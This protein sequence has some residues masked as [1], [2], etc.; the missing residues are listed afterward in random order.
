MSE[1]G[2]SGF[3]NPATNLRMPAAIPSSLMLGHAGIAQRSRRVRLHFAGFMNKTCCIVWEQWVLW[4][5]EGHEHAVVD[6]LCEVLVLLGWRARN[7][8]YWTRV[9]CRLALYYLCAISP[10]SGSML[11][12]IAV[13]SRFGELMWELCFRCDYS[14]SR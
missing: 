5:A 4:E 2:N 9:F 13:C 7:E 3:H 12:R 1:S 10:C 6:R 14:N 8:R 11:M